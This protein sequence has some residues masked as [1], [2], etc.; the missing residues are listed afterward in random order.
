MR[1]IKELLILLLKHE[2]TFKDEGITGLCHL[3]T[4]LYFSHIISDDE[5]LLLNKYTKDNKPSINS[6]HYNKHLYN[7]Y[8]WKVYVWAPRARWLKDE[9]LKFN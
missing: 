5:Y 4:H 3:A 6:I 1:S 7:G 9:I 8:Y 2:R